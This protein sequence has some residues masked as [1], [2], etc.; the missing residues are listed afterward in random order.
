MKFEDKVIIVL[1][2]IIVS[3]VANIVLVLIEGHPPVND[4]DDQFRTLPHDHIA[5]Q[6]EIDYWNNY[7]AEQE[8]LEAEEQR[9]IEQSKLKLI[10]DGVLSAYFFEYWLL[11]LW[12]ISS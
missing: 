6:Q 3:L 7:Q 8:R 4:A 10:N 1:T 2:V 9:Q 5:T 12:R 11:L